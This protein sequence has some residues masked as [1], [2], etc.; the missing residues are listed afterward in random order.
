M[1]GRAGPLLE[2]RASGEAA[3][4]ARRSRRIQNRSAKRT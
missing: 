4:Y 2:Q 3:G 1:A